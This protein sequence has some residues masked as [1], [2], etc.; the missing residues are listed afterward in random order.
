MTEHMCAIEVHSRD[1][2]HLAS[3]LCVQLQ[4]VKCSE[5]GK[6]RGDSTITSA[7]G[8]TTECVRSA[9]CHVCAIAAVLSVDFQLV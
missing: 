7:L 2:N 4:A 8:K 3:L 1:D 6:P 9:L 5:T